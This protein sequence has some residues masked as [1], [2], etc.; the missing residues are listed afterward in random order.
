MELN[1]HDE[2]LMPVAGVPSRLVSDYG[3][4]QES[5]LCPS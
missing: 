3:S 2:W 1:L 5:T 4:T